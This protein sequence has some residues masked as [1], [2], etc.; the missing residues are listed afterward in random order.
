MKEMTNEE[1]GMRKGAEL[2]KSTIL[3]PTK[4]GFVIDLEDGARRTQVRVFEFEVQ[5]FQGGVCEMPV[6]LSVPQAITRL[7]ETMEAMRESLMTNAKCGMTNAE[8]RAA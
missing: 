8:G 4:H 3:Q 5:P 1:C 6:P 7:R 2:S